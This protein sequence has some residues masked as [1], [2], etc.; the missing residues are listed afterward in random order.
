MLDVSVDSFKLLSIEDNIKLY[1]PNLSDAD[2]KAFVWYNRTLGIP[3]TGFEKWWI[4]NTVQNTITALYD[5]DFMDQQWQPVG[6]FQKGDTIGKLT[7]FEHKYNSKNYVV[8]R[9]INGDLVIVLKEALDTEEKYEV[10]M[11][12][13]DILVKQKAL[14]YLNG[15]FIPLHIYTSTDYEILRRAIIEDKE[16]IIE[17]YGAEVFDYHKSIISGYTSMRLDH[18]IVDK[19]YRLNPFGEIARETITTYEEREYSVSDAFEQ[20]VMTLKESDFELVSKSVFRK[21][22]IWNDRKAHTK[23]YKDEEKDEKESE[24]RKEVA[25]AVL[26]CDRLFSTFCVDHLQHDTLLILN[27]K[28]NET[29]NRSILINTSK[30]PVGFISSNMF[31][32]APFE[33]K[34]VQVDAFKFAISRNNWCLALSVGFGKTG[35]AIAALSYLLTT[36]TIKKPL[37]TVPKPVL[38][39]WEKELFGYWLSP[40][41]NI[42]SPHPKK[43][44]KRFFGILTDCGF[45]YMT[46]ANLSKPYLKTARSLKTKTRCITLGSYEA[47]EKMYIADPEIRMFVIARWKD[48]LD[49]TPKGQIESARKSAAKISDLISKLNQVDQEADV[50]FDQLGIDSI[51]FDEAHRLKNMFSGV[52][53]DKS[54]R[55]SSGFKGSPSARA[56][57][58]FYLTQYL[59]KINGRMGFLS[60]TPFSNSPLEVYTM[61]CF[62]NYAEL[63]RNNV[64][65]IQSFVEIFFNETTEYK[66]TDKNN[67]VSE[68]VM[69]SYKNKPILYKILANAFIYRDNPKAADIKRPCIIRYPNMELKLMLKQSILQKMQ[70]DT[71]IDKPFDLEELAMSHPELSQY[72]ADFRQKMREAEYSKKTGE[73]LGAKALAGKILACSK[74]SAVSPFCNSPVALDFITDQPWKELYMYSPKIRFTVDCIFLMSK[75]HANRSE[76]STSFLIYIGLGINILEPLKKALEQICGYSRNQVL[77]LGD[78]DDDDDVKGGKIKYDEVEIISGS[79]STDKEA[80]RRERISELFNKGLVKVLIGTDTIKEGLNLQVNAATLFIL[81]PTWNSTD[82]NQVEGRIHRQGNKFAFAR[83]ITPLVTQTLDSFIYQKYDEKRQRLSDIWQDD[84]ISTTEEMNVDIPAEKQKELILDDSW[85][86]AGI[87]A[88]INGKQF[89]NELNKL[90]DSYDSLVSALAKSDSYKRLVGY[91]TERLPEINEI[92]QNNL[93]I[94]KTVLENW[95]KETPEFL[96]PRKGRLQDLKD[97]YGELIDKVIIAMQSNQVVDMINIFTGSFKGRD[98]SLFLQWENESEFKTYC[99]SLGLNNVKDLLLRETFYSIGIVKNDAPGYYTYDSLLEIYS[100]AKLAQKYIL[101]PEGLTLSSPIDQLN[102]VKA[103]Y[104]QQVIDKRISLQSQFEIDNDN[105]LSVKP[106]YLAQLEREARIELDEE[107][108]LAKKDDILASYFCQMT[109]DQ[110]GV[111]IDDIDLEKCLIPHAL[112]NEDN[113]SAAV[114]LDEI[115]NDYSVYRRLYLEMKRVIINLDTVELGFKETSGEMGDAV[116]PL[117]VEVQQ[118]IKELNPFPHYTGIKVVMEHNYLQ[119]GDLMTD[120]KIEFAVYQHEGIA[121]PL[122]YE[123]NGKGTYN[124]YI[125]NGK[126]TDQKTLN[127]T[128]KFC[129]DAWFPNLV[130]QG[131]TVPV[132]MVGEKVAGGKKGK[133]K[134]DQ[135]QTGGGHNRN[136]K[137]GGTGG[138]G[139]GTGPAP[140]PAPGPSAPDQ[141]INTIGDAFFIDHPDQILGEMSISDYMGMIQ[142]KGTKE[143]VIKY[144]NHLFETQPPKEEKPAFKPKVEEVMTPTMQL[145]KYIYL[146][147]LPDGTFTGVI[148][149][150]DGSE[151]LIKITAPID[152]VQKAWDTYKKTPFVPEPEEDEQEPEVEEPEYEFIRDTRHTPSED[153]VRFSYAT[154]CNEWLKK[155]DLYNTY[156]WIRIDEYASSAIIPE[157]VYAVQKLNHKNYLTKGVFESRLANLDSNEEIEPVEEIIP[158]VEEKPVEHQAET[159]NEKKERFYNEFVER[160][161]D[162][163]IAMDNADSLLKCLQFRFYAMDKLIFV[164]GNKNMRELWSQETGVELPNTQAGTRA[165]INEYFNSIGGGKTEPEQPKPAPEPKKEEPKKEE[166][167]APKEEPKPAK[168]K[169]ERRISIEKQ[170]KALNSTLKYSKDPTA[171]AKVEK[172]VNS[173]TKVLKYL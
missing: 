137:P 55:V 163:G 74:S 72:A 35:C 171:K 172:L 153:P 87:R 75:Y 106:E 158:P 140:A 80:N 173:L 14:L 119:K 114:N 133:K 100:Q 170:I 40:D 150:D 10:K 22:I 76:K 120:P 34:A 33:L 63:V 15:S 97:Y 56:L 129:I 20:W 139:G 138:S 92:L 103:K 78:E 44:W 132:G 61:L 113:L 88:D 62:L 105:E 168:T 155:L 8:V 9:R 49:N 16:H 135:T 93:T 12:E 157:G 41:G 38:K 147:K 71:L 165:A 122:S 45:E 99:K 67:I 156:E 29:Y 101:E 107:N 110:L 2:I 81:A 141:D 64:Y 54:N 51:Y 21:R 167:P 30:V 89:R 37:L 18:P 164:F 13:L 19:R 169:E 126:I 58:A 108:K 125:E 121:I 143:D 79:S 111:K 95:G 144:F 151:R 50:A 102:A 53:A 23:G 48:I 162:K 11:E 3:M 68:S 43:D 82:I 127:K 73:Y 7:R 130:E 124:D 27:R 69:K 17:Y 94:I 65:K 5:V 66:I 109:N 128:V 142:V 91:F 115:K 1:S 161:M 116:M 136:E 86:I 148:H 134:K 6:K 146:R 154:V 145:G 46:I 118:L 36:G 39:N 98:Y 25:D 117:S 159:D 42:T 59:T 149:E 32:D 4:P 123:V 90:Q 166:K 52:S 26:E 96:K 112:V 47:L 77:K 85:E 60:A 57:R 84:G 160:G 152:V 28:I 31:K 70:R 24:E 83:A 104:A 131:R